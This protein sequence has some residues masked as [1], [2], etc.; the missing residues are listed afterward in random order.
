MTLPRRRRGVTLAL[1]AHAAVLISFSDAIV[2]AAVGLASPSQVTRVY[3]LFWSELALALIAAVVLT[4]VRHRGR[5][6]VAGVAVGWLVS[7]ATVFGLGLCWLDFATSL[8]A[9]P[10]PH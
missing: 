6:L 5:E 10:N 2:A 9:Q 7:F 3:V 8:T 1:F 4:L